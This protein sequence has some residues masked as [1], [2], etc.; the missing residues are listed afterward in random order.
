MR[1]VSYKEEERPEK[2]TKPQYWLPMCNSA[3]LIAKPLTATI[4][5][6]DRKCMQQ[7]YFKST[8]QKIRTRNKTA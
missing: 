2:S 8:K 3:K 4:C 1:A 7:R 6:N 5:T